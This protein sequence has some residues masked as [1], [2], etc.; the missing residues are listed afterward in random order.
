MIEA[1]IF[2][3]SLA[4]LV[5]SSD[6]FTEKAELLGL[7]LG[8]PSF[9]VGVTIVAM[10]TSLP[11]LAS[12]IMA[13]LNN[14]SEIVIGNA[15]GSN[16]ANILLV[17]GASTLFL[18]GDTRIKWDL[19]HG[20][21]SFIV[22][23]TLFL[24]VIVWDGVFTLTEALL[25]I[26]GY[27]VYSLYNYEI[28]KKNGSKSEKNRPKF[29]IMDLLI[30]IVSLA[31]VGISADYLIKSGLILAEKLGIGLEILGLTAVAIGTSLPEL[32]VSLSAVRRGNIE[33]AFGNI[34]GSN[35]FNAFLVTGIPRLIGTVV[36]APTILA[37]SIPF[38]VLATIMF[39]VIILDKKVHRYEGSLLLILY[40]FFLVETLMGG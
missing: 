4:V 29:A 21:L 37:S 2:I 23:S 32:M 39:F 19:F 15:V 22:A 33:M 3:L 8:I 6:V 17:I 40:V 1:L 34:S 7:A 31:L 35:I 11:E 12:S 16:I 24:I 36:V 28:H 13:V 26:L 38:L 14:G 5:K 9:I 10:G 27:V 20:D 30:L 18:K 25:L